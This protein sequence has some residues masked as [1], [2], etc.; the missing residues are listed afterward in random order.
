MKIKNYIWV[1]LVIGLIGIPSAAQTRLSVSERAAVVN[2]SIA[3]TCAEKPPRVARF[4]AHDARVFS[5]ERVANSLNGVWLGRVSGEYDPQLL[6]RDGFLN[7]DYY[8]IVDI[9]RGEA[10]VYEEVTSKRSGGALRAKMNTASAPNWTYVW[11]NREQYKNPAPRQI[12]E[13]IKVSDNVNDA[14]EIISSSLGVKVR[15]E[16]V[17]SDVWQQLVETKFFD[18]PKRS[19]AYAG[20]LFKPVRL[21]NIESAGRGSLFELRMVGEYRGNGQTAAKFIPREPIHNVEAGHFLGVSTG[22]VSART[23]RAARRVGVATSSSGDFLSASVGLG[24]AMVGPKSDADAA[25][26]STQ[27]AFDKVTIGLG[28]AGIAST[29]APPEKAA[30]SGSARASRRQQKAHR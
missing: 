29:V 7:V 25:V 24:N 30:S 3:S 5:S 20:V 13:F 17:L 1:V 15:G 18:D 12:H 23:A 9:K 6:A 27:M 28:S 19:L 11:C 26:F 14:Q 2:T 8:M 4:L 16:V 10:L 22:A 21:G